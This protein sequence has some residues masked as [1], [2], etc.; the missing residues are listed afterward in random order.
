[1]CADNAEDG[2]QAIGTSNAPV[3]VHDETEAEDA[4]EVEDS[5][6]CLNREILALE[7]RDFDDE[8]RAE[9]CADNAEG[10]IQVI[11]ASN[12][13]VDVCDETEAEDTS[14]AEDS[15]ACLNRKILTLEMRDF[16]DEEGIG[17]DLEE[18]D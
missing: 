1:M 2:I 10:G 7:M 5:E 17:S 12:A 11:G 15:E 3:D 6:V 8:E 13:P 4:S 16:D 18:D 9:M 14:G